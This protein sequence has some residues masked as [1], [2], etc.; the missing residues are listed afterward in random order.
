[1]FILCASLSILCIARARLHEVYVILMFVCADSYFRWTNIIKQ[2]KLLERNSKNVYQTKIKHNVNEYCTNHC[3]SVINRFY[4]Y[5]NIYF[6]FKFTHS[7]F[8]TI[9]KFIYF[10]YFQTKIVQ[11]DN[12]RVKLQVYKNANKHY[13][14]LCTIFPFNF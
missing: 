13:K 4:R 8:E 1:M 2:S 12:A 6:P 5:R 9:F 14:A 11:L 7:Q 3:F 10:V